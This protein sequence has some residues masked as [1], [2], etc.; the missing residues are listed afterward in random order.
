TLAAAEPFGHQGSILKRLRESERA[1]RGEIDV[2][3]A[4]S[5]DEARARA[6]ISTFADAVA[7]APVDARL[8]LARHPR[9]PDVCGRELDVEG[10]LAALVAGTH[11]DDEMID[12]AVR[13]VPAKISAVDLARVEVEKVVAS[14][15]TTFVLFGTGAGR[16]INIAN[17]ASRFD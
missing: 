6:L 8:D 17:A 14:Y 4:W 12:L 16:A 3:V 1:R 11:D 2:P 10:S 7:R 5:I 15:E 13:Y 9:I